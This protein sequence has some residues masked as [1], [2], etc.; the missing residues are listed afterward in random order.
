[1]SRRS[2]A[3]SSDRAS[4]S[5]AWP[6]MC[7]WWNEARLALQASPSPAFRGERVGGLSAKQNCRVGKGALCAVPT[8]D[9]IAILNGGHAFALSTGTS[10]DMSW[11]QC[12]QTDGDKQMKY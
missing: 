10:D 6:W 9:A 3:S 12:R 11:S 2:T 4:R 1:M 5:S 7:C 8:T